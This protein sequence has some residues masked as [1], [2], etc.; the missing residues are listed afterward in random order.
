MKGLLLKDFY[1]V[2]RHCWPFAVFLIFWP[3]LTLTGAPPT[4]MLFSCLM[5]S[6]LPSTLLAYDERA[7]WM[8]YADAL[9]YTRTQIVSVK[10]IYG[11]LAEGIMIISI[12]VCMSINTLFIQEDNVLT[13]REIAFWCSVY[14]LVGAVMTLYFPFIFKFGVEKG[15]LAYILIVVGHTVT[16]T[17][18]VNSSFFMN[19]DVSILN[20]SS[21]LIASAVVLVIAALIYAASWGLSVM[22]YSKREL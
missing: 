19:P 22:L 10:Y 8:N 17:S 18:I 11:L 3:M 20:P 15:R 1:V 5:A 4:F 16:Y 21:P 14:L 12:A 9:P 7:R 2:I 13:F 6:M